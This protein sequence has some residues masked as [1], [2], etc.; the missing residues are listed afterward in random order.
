MI[1]ITRD[2]PAAPILGLLVAAAAA[3]STMASPVVAVGLLG[4]LAA[5][6]LLALPPLLLP[7]LVVSSALD[8]FQLSA[9][10]AQ[11][12]IDIIAVLLI[13]AV[14]G[15]RLAVR[16]LS[17]RSL[18]TPLLW[19]LIAY[20]SFNLFS[21]LLFD[22][23]RSRGLRLDAEILAAV[24]SYV[25]A[26]AL[27]RTRRNLD[28]IISFLW[29]ATVGE[30]LLGLLLLVT[31]LG[32][33]T[34]FGVQIGDYQNPMVFGTQWEANIFGSFLLGNFFI[35]L[36]DYLMRRQTAL[37]AAGLLMVVMGIAASQTRTVWLALLLGT[38]LFALLVR[39]ARPG[40]KMLPIL[41]S[42]PILALVGLLAGSTTSFGQRLLDVVNLQSS[43]ASGRL[44]IFTTALAEWKHNPLFG[45]GTGSYHYSQV[46]GAPPP[47]IP[48]LF[49]LTLHDAGIFGL[50]SLLLVILAFYRA[51][52]RSLQHA[53]GLSY[54]ISGAIAGSTALFLAFQTTTGL[55][56][57]YPWLVVAIGVSAARLSSR[58]ESTTEP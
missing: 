54:V 33:L 58:Q 56:F 14:L 55:W 45:T 10:G 38:I 52:F 11:I 13:A 34:T 1:R 46:P 15:N 22:P 48:N 44:A 25:A 36:G 2:S 49:L 7:L 37:R 31:Y 19:P 28:Q 39:Y 57:A 41:A 20:L 12:R 24:L 40:A 27:V 17:W 3:L 35:L 47:W 5:I 51:T 30:A 9:G 32:H 23:A 21:T 53:G 18:V 42:I 26:T 50:A 29:I 6:V 4:A 16:T 8:R 43:S